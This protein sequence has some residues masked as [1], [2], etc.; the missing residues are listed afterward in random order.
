MTRAELQLAVPTC[1]HCSTAAIDHISDVVKMNAT[2]SILENLQLHRTK[3]TALLN[4]VI[5]P[6]LRDELI[7][8]MKGKKFSLMVDES[9]DVATEKLLAV[10]SR[11]F[12]EKI[13]E[14]KAAF[15]GLYPVVQA[16]GEA[17]FLTLT[18]CL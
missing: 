14:I 13:G 10:R 9:T 2:G 17:L 16:T 1:C 18:E 15:L 8:D 11:Y 7:S 3:C 6:S 5:S 12:S 4:S